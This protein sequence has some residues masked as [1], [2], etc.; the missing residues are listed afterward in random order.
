MG[1]RRHAGTR[2]LPGLSEAAWAPP[3][4]LRLAR[5]APSRLRAAP[6]CYKR[7]RMVMPN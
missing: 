7:L 4:T 1:A 6:A 5:A 3:Y 2:P